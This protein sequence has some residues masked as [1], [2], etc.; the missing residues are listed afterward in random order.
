M[1]R[2]L[3]DKSNRGSKRRKGLLPKPHSKQKEKTKKPKNYL[4]DIGVRLPK[5]KMHVI[6]TDFSHS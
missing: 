6:L 1:E 4:M 3:P 5:W 2:S